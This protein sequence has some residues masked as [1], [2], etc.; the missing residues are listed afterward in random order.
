MGKVP[1]EEFS[2]NLEF[3]KRWQVNG[4]DLRDLVKEYNI[5]FSRAYQIKTK[6][7]RKPQYQSKLSGYDTDVAS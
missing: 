6:V 1:E 4:E 3:Y 7:E 5:S 2:R